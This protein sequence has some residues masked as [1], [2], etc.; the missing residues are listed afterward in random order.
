MKIKCEALESRYWSNDTKAPGAGHRKAALYLKLPQCSDALR[1]PLSPCP[2]A[3][4]LEDGVT[5]AT[6]DTMCPQL[7]ARYL[8]ALSRVLWRSR[9]DFLR[10]IGVIRVRPLFPPQKWL[11]AK[12]RPI[13]YYLSLW[14]KT[15][16]L[17]GRET[18]RTILLANYAPHAVKGLIDGSDREAAV[19]ALLASVGPIAGLNSAT[20]KVQETGQKVFE[21]EFH[22]NEN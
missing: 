2:T 15:K 3:S 9:G 12:P 21:L 6:A 17:S 4:L 19:K 10:V 20:C 16:P 7:R 8:S 18:M 14:I 11:I 13:G 5:G 1:D 22:V